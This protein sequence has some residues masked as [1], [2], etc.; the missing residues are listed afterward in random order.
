MVYTDKYSSTN[1]INGLDAIRIGGNSFPKY[2]SIDLNPYI[3][4]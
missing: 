2:M 4:K 1:T 3:S